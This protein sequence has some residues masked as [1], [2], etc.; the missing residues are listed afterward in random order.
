MLRR[1]D[2][3]VVG[4]GFGGAVSACRLAQAGLRVGVL[5][6]G[7]RYPMGTF[8]RNWENPFDGWLWR[9]DQGLFDVREFGR[10]MTVVQSAAYGG[11]SHVYANVQLRMPP[12]SFRRGWP[13]GYTREALDPYYDLVAYMLDITPVSADQPYGLPPKTRLMREVAS[14]LGRSDQFC[15]PNLAV[16]FGDPTTARPNKF[17]VKQYGCRHCGEC[18]IGC[19]I[20]AKN[21]LDLNYLAVAEQHGADVGTRCEVTTITPVRDGYRVDYRD[22]ASGTRRD[23]RARA[24]FLCAGAVNSTEL[25]LRCRDQYRTLPA[26]SER[27]GCDYSANGDFLGFAFHADESFDPWVGPTITTGIVY[28]RSSGADRHWFIFEE[29]GFPRQIAALLQVLSPEHRRRQ[30]PLRHPEQVTGLVRRGARDRVRAPGDVGHDT[31]VFL[32]MG[33]DKANGRMA[34]HPHTHE[35]CIDWDLAGNEALYDVEERLCA[36]IADTLGAAMADN[37]LWQYLRVPVAVHNLGGCV[38]ADDPGR[39]VTDGNGEV[40]GYPGLYVL[41]GAC[42]PAATGVNPSHTIAAVAERNIETAIAGMTGRRHRAPEWKHVHRVTDPLSTLVI[43][44]KGTRPPRTSPIGLAFTQPMRGYLQTDGDAPAGDGT[45]RRRL[46]VS[47]TLTVA[48]PFLDEFLENR[49]HPMTAVGTVRAETL[50]TAEGAPVRHGVVNL[51]AD[52]G[53]PGVRRTLYTLPFLGMDGRPYLMEGC[54]DLRADRPLSVGPATSPLRVQVRAGHSGKGPV[55]A[56]GELHIPVDQIPRQLASVRITG[57]TSP[58]RWAESL[59]RFGQV[60][61]EAFWDAFVNPRLPWRNR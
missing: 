33:R 36:D 10:E 14:R 60:Y 12:E 53:D 2:A 37:P 5:E 35:L 47:A 17:G 44:E 20:Q 16:N 56:T 6:R 40:Y 57:T 19:N 46:A 11:G 21:T 26:L 43:P 4:T 27:L 41:D 8:P 42:L 49:G 52:T 28:D 22:H 25:L 51:L 32:A 31:A 61:A 7:R 50:T 38:M 13:G 39:G 54:L 23:V 9:H 15:Y 59:A 48:A 18:D 24:V 30:G 55:V 45:G 29:G 58:L 3:I 1:Y 34:L